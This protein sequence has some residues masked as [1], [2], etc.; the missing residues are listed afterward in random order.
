MSRC[1]SGVEG[2]V[3]KGRVTILCSSMKRPGESLPIL[4]VICQRDAVHSAREGGD[5]Q[6]WS[7]FLHHA[8]AK[9]VCHQGKEPQ[10]KAAA[11]WGPKRGASEALGKW[12]LLPAWEA[13][14]L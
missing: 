12:Q 3:A 10:G 4:G 13:Q 1:F 9:C 8:E 11:E 2:G 14:D 7:T 6:V 5:L